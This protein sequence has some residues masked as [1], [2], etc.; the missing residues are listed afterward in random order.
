[1][2]RDYS[3]DTLRTIATILVVFL[4]VSAQYVTDGTVNRIYDTGF[5]IGNIFNSFSRI[6]VPLFVMISGRYLIGKN[7]PLE[8]FYS[9]RVSKILIPLIVWSIGYTIYEF[10]D[11]HAI[12]GIWNY[13]AVLKSLV[14]GQ[15]YFHLWYLF[16]LIGLYAVTPA[17]TYYVSNISRR[18]CW[19]IAS[20][21]MG[22]GFLVH[23]YDRFF[24][25]HT[26]F[27][28]GFVNYLGYFL[29]GYLIKDMKK[30]SN[31]L[32]IAIYAI[33]SL[34]TVVGSYFT[35]VKFNS[36][37]LYGYLTPFVIIA[38]LSFYKYFSQ[39]KIQKNILSDI[40]PLTF[41]IYLIHAVIFDLTKKA[42]VY[43]N[44][45][46]MQNPMIGFSVKFI[47]IFGISLLLVYLINKSKS[48]RKII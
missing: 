38:S 8:A 46:F 44:L 21:F 15:P 9:K 27:I 7:E 19:I 37:A 5:W 32:L 11:F 3:I 35:A 22:L 20:V 25:N 28:F 14:I 2:E 40:A 17:I 10:I 18:K 1:M 13:K 4:H 39:I 42:D 16:M 12:N 45:E 6:C 33:S 30:Y 48:L 29:M 47:V 26:L 23:F 41:G 36:L 34:A 24:N 31:S 43:L